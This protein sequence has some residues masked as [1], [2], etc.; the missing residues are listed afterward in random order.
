MSELPLTVSTRSVCFAML[1]IEKFSLS[2][3]ESRNDFVVCPDF[4]ERFDC[5]EAV[6]IAVYGL[7]ADFVKP[8]ETLSDAVS[9]FIPSSCDALR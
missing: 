4:P 6:L 3:C 2:A 1:S 9:A 8:P 5:L 7:L